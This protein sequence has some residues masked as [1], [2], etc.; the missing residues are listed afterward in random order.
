MKINIEI[1]PFIVPNFV[2]AKTKTRLQ[3]EGFVSSPSWPL[4]EVDPEILD[5]LCE[6]FRL[7]VFRKA[8]VQDPRGKR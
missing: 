1:K 3:Q 4:S 5:E 8:G 7:D 6:Q 2:V